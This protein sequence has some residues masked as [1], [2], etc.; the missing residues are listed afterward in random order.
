ME[1]N[2]R[3]HDYCSK[4]CASKA[5]Q[6]KKCKYPGCSKPCYVDGHKV[7]D[8]CGKNHA[9]LY[10]SSASHQ[11]PV[12]QAMSR[13]STSTSSSSSKSSTS[14]KNTIVFL[15]ASDKKYQE[16]RN[17]WVKKWIKPGYPT[18]NIL[19]I[20]KINCPDTVRKAYE[21]Y[22]QRVI[23]SRP[24]LKIFG[25]GGPGNEQRRFHG[26][27]QSCSLGLN[28][29]STLCNG[30]NCS[31][32]SIIKTGWLISKAGS[33]TGTKFG[34]GA[35]FTSCST[36][37]HD[38]NQGS[39]QGLGKNVRSMFIAKVV[40]GKGYVIP[41]ASYSN[42]APPSGYDSIIATQGVTAGINYDELI[43]YENASALP[44]YLVVYRY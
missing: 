22:R 34:K 40:V 10:L 11:L 38:Y 35:Y 32:C 3:V 39:E 43:V 23:A 36:K 31:V 16:L 13:P 27:R 37:S 8:F 7:H 6:T 18:P 21:A 24:G 2:G 20:L 28:N 9:Q 1:A 15:Q 17:Q 30:S 25:H 26:T 5:N 14:N 33:A 12:L 42:T 19:A 29:N 41:S 44:S 4:T